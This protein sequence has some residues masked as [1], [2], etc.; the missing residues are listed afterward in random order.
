[1]VIQGVYKPAP[2]VLRPVRGSRMEGAFRVSQERA[3]A[4][5][6]ATGTAAVAMPSLLAMQEAESAALQDRDAKRHGTAVLDKLTGLQRSLL[7]P[8][9]PDLDR[10]AQLASQP[11]QAAD[12]RLAGVLRAIQLRARIELARHRPAASR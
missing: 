7:G 12:P 11:A 5:E 6:A 3:E 1:M 8:D 9:G 10:L 2:G 4:A